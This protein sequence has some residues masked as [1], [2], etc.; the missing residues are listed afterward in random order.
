MEKN[1]DHLEFPHLD[2]VKDYPEDALQAAFETYDMD[3]MDK[4]QVA[5]DEQI[6]EFW[7][8][9]D[10]EDLSTIDLKGLQP[11]D[12]EKL[13]VQEEKLRVKLEKQKKKD[14][15]LKNK[16]SKEKRVD[17][18]KIKKQQRKSKVVA[19]NPSTPPPNQ[20][21]LDMDVDATPRASGSSMFIFMDH[22]ITFTEY[23]YLR[24]SHQ[25][26]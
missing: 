8:A 4:L 15:Q 24:T 22:S 5:T 20:L 2:H 10:M 3:E 13:L 19:A 25:E 17:L 14:D 1:H 6:E 26:E 9:K 21:A 11:D 7:G 16:P 18:T 12:K 23:L